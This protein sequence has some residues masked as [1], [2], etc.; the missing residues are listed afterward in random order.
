MLVFGVKSEG[1]GP[2]GGAGCRCEAIIKMDI[3]ETRWEGVDCICLFQ[4]RDKWPP[5]VHTVMNL[6][7]L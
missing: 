7:F 5:L 2:L 3:N 6:R 1:R 4:D